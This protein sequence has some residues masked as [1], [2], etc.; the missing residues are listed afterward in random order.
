MNWPPFSF[1]RSTW[2]NM[3]DTNRLQMYKVQPNEKKSTAKM[4]KCKRSDNTRSLCVQFAHFCWIFNSYL[5]RTFAQNAP[6]FFCC[7]GCRCWMHL[8][9]RRLVVCLCYLY[10]FRFFCR[11]TNSQPNGHRCDLSKA[12]ERKHCR[13]EAAEK[14]TRKFPC[15]KIN[16]RYM[17]VR[18]VHVCYR[19]GWKT[20]ECHWKSDTIIHLTAVQCPQR[21]QCMQHTQLCVCTV[22]AY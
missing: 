16:T 11:F 21:S 2:T 15:Y 14:R 22:C 12:T 3:N 1:V 20:A 17:W 6:H 10:L 8:E 18:S 9:S 13:M 4:L 19:G 7:Y 5:I